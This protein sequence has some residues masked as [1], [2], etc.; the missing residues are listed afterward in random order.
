[1]VSR[2]P[3]LLDYET[4]ILTVGR[5]P[6]FP[7]TSLPATLSTKLRIPLLLSLGRLVPMFLDR[8]QLRQRPHKPRCHSGASEVVRGHASFQ[9]NMSYAPGR[10][11]QVRRGV[12]DAVEDFIRHRRHIACSSR[13]GQDSPT[14]RRLPGP[15]T[16]ISAPSRLRVRTLFPALS[17]APSL[18]RSLLALRTLSRA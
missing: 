18:E 13:I 7:C 11:A 3:S 14:L 16:G 9:G 2:T 6:Q 8:L 12:G 5:Y 1:M 10:E 15:A 4:S 17:Y